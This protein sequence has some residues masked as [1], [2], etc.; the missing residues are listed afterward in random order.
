MGVN[1]TKLT[2]AL[3]AAGIE[4]N[5]CN[6]NGVVWDKLNNEIQ[7][8]GDVL[9]IINAY[10]PTETPTLSIYDQLADIYQQLSDLQAQNDSLTRALVSAKVLTVDQASSIDS[11][12]NS[13]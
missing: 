5:G 10:D 1:V 12:T 6:S 9:A 4:T 11:A 3:L 13:I 7:K 8:R 2:Q